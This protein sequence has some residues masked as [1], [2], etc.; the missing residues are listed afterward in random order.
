MPDSILGFSGDW[1]FLSNLYPSPLE[2]MNF[3]YPCVENAFQAAKT[4]DH[5][6]QRRLTELSPD[7]A[8]AYGRMVPLRPDW[9]EVKLDVMTSLLA[10][11]F[12]IPVLRRRLI[13][14]APKELVNLNWWGDRYWGRVK[15]QGENHLG[16]LLMELRETL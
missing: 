11:K 1:A 13:A 12:E 2:W 16:R 3:L 14:S 9:E 5:E 7:D 4:S 10:L 6:V 8:A 15:L